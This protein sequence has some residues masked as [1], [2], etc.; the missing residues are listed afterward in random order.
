MTETRLPEK[1]E[2]PPWGCPFGLGQVPDG[3]DLHVEG[4]FFRLLEAGMGGEKSMV[5]GARGDVGGW[6]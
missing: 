4:S 2:Q 5:P 6:D 1:T 3:R